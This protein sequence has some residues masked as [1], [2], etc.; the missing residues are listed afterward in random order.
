MISLCR[1]RNELQHEYPDVRASSIHEGV[2][3]LLAE[4]GPFMQSY[5]AWL[6]R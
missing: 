4:L 1:L 2:K 3:V 5:R 6:K